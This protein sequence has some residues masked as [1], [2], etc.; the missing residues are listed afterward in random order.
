MK[1]FSL[2][3]VSI[4][5]ENLSIVLDFCF[6]RP[7]LKRLLDQRFQGE[8]AHLNSLSFDLSEARA[9]KAAIELAL[10]LRFLDD[11]E[12]SPPLARPLGNLHVRG[13]AEQPMG[14]RDVA[15]KIIHASALTWDLSVPDS[16]RLVCASEDLEKWKRAEIDVVALAGF[17][18]TMM[19]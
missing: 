10:F 2:P 6:A 15:N 18:G 7:S 9:N 14:V 17:V 12:A 5:R 8:W 4:I 11:R 1:V 19:V 16:P 3:L 13:G